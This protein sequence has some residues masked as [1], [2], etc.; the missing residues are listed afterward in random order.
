MMNDDH[1]DHDYDDFPDDFFDEVPDS[2]FDACKVFNPKQPVLINLSADASDD[3]FGHLPDEFFEEVPD[4]I[5]CQTASCHR[6]YQ[7]PRRS[8]VCL[9]KFSHAS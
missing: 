9:L 4:S 6:L 2:I 8:T 3:E 5:L 7:N 1:S